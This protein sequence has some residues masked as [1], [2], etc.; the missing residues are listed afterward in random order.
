M[1]ERWGSRPTSPGRFSPIGAS[2][3]GA[4]A[5]RQYP[6]G[7]AGRPPAPPGQAL[8]APAAAEGGALER[9]RTGCAPGDRKGVSA[10]RCAGMRHGLTRCAYPAVTVVQLGARS[11]PVCA[12]H[13]KL[14]LATALADRPAHRGQEPQLGV[15]GFQ[16]AHGDDI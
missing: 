7:R 5:G 2:P 11:W 15:D 1:S 13:L 14:W 6:A 10:G 12:W 8:D 16:V 3:I 4:P 9:D